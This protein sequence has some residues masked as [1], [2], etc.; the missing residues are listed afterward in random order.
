MV[1]IDASA[2]SG[3]KPVEA[4]PHDSRHDECPCMHVRFAS[5]GVK[6]LDYLCSWGPLWFPEPRLGFN[7]EVSV[8]GVDCHEEVVQEALESG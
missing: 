5:L 4:K 3:S 2:P 1:M 8:V 7:F 6:N